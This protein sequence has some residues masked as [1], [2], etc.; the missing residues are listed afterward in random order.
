MGKDSFCL[1]WVLVVGSGIEPKA[2]IISYMQSILSLN[3]SPYPVQITYVLTYKFK[4]I[5][6]ALV[7]I[8][9]KE[10]ICWL[11]LSRDI[12]SCYCKSEPI[13]ALL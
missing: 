13:S 12:Y 1:F 6:V 3:H 10:V 5:N 2:S 4:V 11:H 7:T 9:K 8:Y